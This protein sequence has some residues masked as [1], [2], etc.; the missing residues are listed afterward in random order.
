[1]LVTPGETEGGSKGTQQNPEGV[2]YC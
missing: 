2:Q 1:M